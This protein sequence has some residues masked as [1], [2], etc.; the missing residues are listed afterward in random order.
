VT[1]IP[2]AMV[3]AGWAVTP[4]DT[5]N[6]IGSAVALA[7][8]SVDAVLALARMSPV[9]SGLGDDIDDLVRAELDSELATEH[10]ADHHLSSPWWCHHL[11]TVV[12]ASRNN[13]GGTRCWGHSP[14]T[15]HAGAQGRR[16]GFLRTGA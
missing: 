4:S 12:A 14:E 7:G 5:T 2:A 9:E 13:R 10:V 11:V 1:V 6:T 15:R 8:A 16:E 3:A